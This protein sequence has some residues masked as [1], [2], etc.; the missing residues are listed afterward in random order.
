MGLAKGDQEI[1]KCEL[2]SEYMLFRGCFVDCAVC[3]A[4][5]ETTSTCKVIKPH[6]IG[7]KVNIIDPLIC[8]QH[9]QLSP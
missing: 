4:K 7:L 5:E 1:S 8:P 2:F 6:P 3:E 9:I